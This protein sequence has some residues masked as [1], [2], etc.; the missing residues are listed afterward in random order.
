M[1]APEVPAS[2]PVQARGALRGWL[3][4]GLGPLEPAFRAD[5]LPADRARAVIAVVGFAVGLVLVA[6][7]DLWLAVS[8]EGTPGRVAIVGAFLLL[9]GLL[10]LYIRQAATAAALDTALLGWQVAGVATVLAFRAAG[11]SAV[12]GTTIVLLAFGAYAVLPCRLLFRIIPAA[13]LTIGD[14]AIEIRVLEMAPRIVAGTVM[15]HIF[16]HLAGGLSAAGFL[17]MRRR[18][19]LGRREAAAGRQALEQLA[20][21][22]GL[23]GVLRRRR[24]L[25]LAEA[26]LQRYQRHQRPFAVLI[27]DLDHFKRVNDSHGHLVGDAVLREFAGMLRQ[28]SRQFDLVGRLGGEEFGILLPETDLPEAAE[29]AT[30]IV[31]SCRELVVRE[32]GVEIR[33]TCSVGATTVGS[34]DLAV[35]ALLA[36][37]DGAMYAAKVGGR[38]RVELALPG[39]TPGPEPVPHP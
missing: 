25:E 26:E 34:A 19:F 38:N 36:R 13:L 39:E 6:I 4:F 14:L 2:G 28:E 15:A 32:A 23:T 5:C 24:W 35:E 9:S 31:E 27:A 18:L 21:T 3:G 30:R 1:T 11:L 7:T 8:P 10:W 37:A 22:D 12:D 29:V 16:V 33:L 17:A 20:N